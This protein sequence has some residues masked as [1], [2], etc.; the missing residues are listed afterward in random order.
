MFH[1]RICDRE[2]TRLN[3]R[4]SIKVIYLR[5]YC[6][7]FWEIIEQSQLRFLSFPDADYVSWNSTEHHCL[8]GEDGNAP[9]N[10]GYRTKYYSLISYE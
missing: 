3:W 6:E 7:L 8:R 2:V 1:R 10:T 5:G 4:V 9:P